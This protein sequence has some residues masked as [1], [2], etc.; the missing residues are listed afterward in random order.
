MAHNRRWDL[1]PSTRDRSGTGAQSEALETCPLLP[2]SKEGTGLQPGTDV[3]ETERP[4]I[5]ISSLDPVA[6]PPVPKVERLAALARAAGW[7]VRVGYA[8]SAVPAR[9][10]LNGNEGRGEH[11]RQSIAVHFRRPG[12]R[13]WALLELCSDWPTTPTGRPAGWRFVHAFIGI[14]RLTLAQLNE[15]IGQ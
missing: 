1:Y 2:L 5:I 4:K 3:V 10:F 11:E 9:T 14:E 8:L 12:A 6:L 15:R 7:F 13:G